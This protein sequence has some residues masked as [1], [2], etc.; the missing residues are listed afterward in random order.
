MR[1]IDNDRF[2]AQSRDA[3]WCN[4]L[5]NLNG[6]QLCAILRFRR[7]FGTTQ[8]RDSRLSGAKQ[9]G[10]VVAERIGN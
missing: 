8:L 1:N 9:T 2:V 10:S 5:C 6:G 3:A 4:S 7:F